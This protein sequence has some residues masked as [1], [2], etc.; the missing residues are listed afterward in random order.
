MKRRSKIND[1]YQKVK[2]SIA[3]S[4]GLSVAQ[5]KAQKSAALMGKVEELR[6]LGQQIQR[7]REELKKAHLPTDQYQLWLQAKAQSGNQE[8]LAE[9]RSQNTGLERKTGVL[10][11]IIGSVGGKQDAAILSPDQA[12]PIWKRLRYTVAQNG[13]VTYYKERKELLVDVGRKL[14]MVDRSSDTIERGLRLA[15]QKWG[16]KMTLGGSDDFIRQVIEVAAHKNMKIEFVDPAHNQKFE[17][18]K[19]NART[20]MEYSNRYEEKALI[21]TTDKKE[22]EEERLDPRKR[23]ARQQAQRAQRVKASEVV[24]VMQE[25]ER[26]RERSRDAPSEPNGV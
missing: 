26:D 23:A 25:Q 18:L 6:S 24:E 7:E 2:D 10:D 1:F 9:L 17:E 3:A 19:K 8:A 22:E 11:R 12:E 13:D 14:F 4:Q 15:A 5:K 16:G 20:G 21:S